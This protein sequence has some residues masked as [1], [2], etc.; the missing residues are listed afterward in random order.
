MV[1]GPVKSIA[2]RIQ[3]RLSIARV[4]SR[5]KQRAARTQHPRGLPQR[6]SWGLRVLQNVFHDHYLE[7]SVRKRELLER[8]LFGRETEFTTKTDCVLADIDTGRM[9]AQIPGGEKRVTTCAPDIEKRAR[10]AARWRAR[11][12]G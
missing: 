3:L 1:F 9:E 2:L 8:S 11:R 7:G 12:A 4:W 5:D 10:L 6:R